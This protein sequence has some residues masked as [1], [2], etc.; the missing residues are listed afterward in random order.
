[1]KTHTRT[2]D[3]KHQIEQPFQKLCK[4]IL[5][6]EV[7]RF[8]LFR[9]GLLLHYT[10]IVLVYIVQSFGPFYWASDEY[11]MLQQIHIEHTHTDTHLSVAKKIDHFT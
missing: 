8:R 2:Y 5:F 7:T 6:Y 1:M 4:R 9:V 11:V 3:N 10:D